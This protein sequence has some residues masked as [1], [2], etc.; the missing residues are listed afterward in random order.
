VYRRIGGVGRIGG[1]KR[2][3]LVSWG[4]LL[5]LNFGEDVRL[6]F[7]KKILIYHFFKNLGESQLNW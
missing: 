7:T 4:Y 1:G 6:L 2:G 3:V 5:M